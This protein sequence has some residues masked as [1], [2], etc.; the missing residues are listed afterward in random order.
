MVQISSLLSLD[1]HTQVDE[2]WND[3]W[4]NL[5]RDTK[6]SL[7]PFR[8]LLFNRSEQRWFSQTPGKV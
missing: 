5:N 4:L 6:L 3:L 1:D 8:S 2:S 7:H